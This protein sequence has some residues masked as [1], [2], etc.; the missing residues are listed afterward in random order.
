MAKAIA[1][2]GAKVHCFDRLVHPDPEFSV[3][4]REAEGARGSLH[5]HHVDVRSRRVLDQIIA[6]FVSKSGRIDGLVAASGVQRAKA[7]IDYTSQ[8]VSELLH[9]NYTGAFMPANAVARQMI[10]H[11]QGGSIVLVASMSG[12]I[13]NKGLNCAVYN[14]SKV[15]VIQLA[16]NLAIEWG[17]SGIRVNALCPGHIITP[18]V[19]QNLAEV[20]GLKQ[21][22]EHENMLGRLAAPEEFAGAIVFLLSEA[23]SFMTGTSV[24]IDGG[25]TAW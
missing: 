11:R 4:Q 13:A 12:L 25:H 15:A 14:S 23:S 20:P 18:M 7:A 19:Q 5:Y 1:Q 10:R 17:R 9:I 21:I 22:W 6:D 8:E 2:R 24:V 3:L 16:R